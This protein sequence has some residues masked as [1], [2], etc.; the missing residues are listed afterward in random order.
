MWQGLI[1]GKFSLAFF[2]PKS[3]DVFMT[4]VSDKFG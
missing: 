4:S 3:L 2:A 1:I